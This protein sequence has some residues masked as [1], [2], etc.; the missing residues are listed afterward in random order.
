[1][2]H[3]P[4]EYFVDMVWP[5]LID[6]EVQQASSPSL[7]PDPSGTYPW[8]SYALDSEPFLEPQE[9]SLQNILNG[10][11]SPSYLIQQC[12][13]V[14]QVGTSIVSWLIGLS[15]ENCPPSKATEDKARVCDAVEASYRYSETFNIGRQVG[16]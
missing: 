3:W 11:E 16:L 9:P 4:L 12:W 8:T 13:F 6:I 1:M 15:R 7:L 10:R 5:D 2:K 14:C